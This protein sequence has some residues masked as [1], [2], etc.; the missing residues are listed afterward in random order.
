[1]VV[2]KSI[3]CSSLVWA[4]TKLTNN[5]WAWVYQKIQKFKL[6]LAWLIIQAKLQLKLKLNIEF[7]NSRSNTSTL[8]SLY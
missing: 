8:S 3:E 7:L 2:S 4:W 5:I 1:M 6:D